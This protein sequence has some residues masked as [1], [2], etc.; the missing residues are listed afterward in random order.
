MD[1][2]DRKNNKIIYPDLSYKITGIL[3]SVHNELG[4]YAREKQYGDLLENKL[5]EINL[6]YERE[7]RISD[8]GNVLD[9]II[10][11]KIVL[12]LKSVVAINRDNY[13]QVQNYLQ[14]TNLKLGLLVNFRAKYL[15]SIRIIRIDPCRQE[16]S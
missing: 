10:D 14:V 8:S 6:P 16:Y 1:N 12:E 3:F 15:K 9:F 13:R 4:Q 5:N 11:K 7:V 2:S